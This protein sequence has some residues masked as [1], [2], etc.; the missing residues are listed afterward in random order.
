MVL[1]LHYPPTSIIFSAFSE[2]Y[3]QLTDCF[4]PHFWYSDVFNILLRYWFYLAQ[5]IFLKYCLYA[6]CFTGIFS[7]IL[8]GD[9][10]I[11]YIRSCWFDPLQFSTWKL[12]SSLKSVMIFNSY[13][14]YY[15]VNEVKT[16]HL[17][18]ICHAFYYSL[19]VEWWN[20]H[21]TAPKKKENKTKE[22]NSCHV[23]HNLVREEP[24]NRI[25]CKIAAVIN[26]KK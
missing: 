12:P 21:L 22:Q 23:P 13:L 20:H 11:N 2:A 14:I 4:F 18:F 17:P 7:D 9:D 26:I 15:S 25:K 10:K 16:F 8:R 3:A 19:V 1:F 6:L 24:S 5:L